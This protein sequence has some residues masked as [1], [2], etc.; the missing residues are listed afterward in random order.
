MCAHI[1]VLKM[2]TRKKN[3]KSGLSKQILLKIRGHRNDQQIH[4]I[5]ILLIIREMKMEKTVRY[6][7]TPESITSIKNKQ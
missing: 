4:E 1:E 6:H 2:N 5:I 3:I 7:L